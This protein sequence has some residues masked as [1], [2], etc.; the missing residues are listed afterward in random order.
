M[1]GQV[2]IVSPGGS[3]LAELSAAEAR[4]WGEERV[5]LTE[6]GEYDYELQLREGVGGLQCPV[7]R[8]S[9][10]SDANIERGRILP[11]GH[12]GLLV[13]HLVDKHD[14]PIASAGV[15]VRSVKVGY[16]S[17]YRSMLN[18]IAERSTDLLLRLPAPAFLRLRPVGAAEPR[19]IAQ[20][21]AF[22][23][24]VVRS[25]AFRNAI[26]RIVAAPHERTVRELQ[27]KDVRIGFTT[28][29][30]AMRQLASRH[31]RI[32]VPEA[33]ALR[34][35]LP[36]LPLEVL[37][38]RSGAGH[39]TPENRFVKFVLAEL[40]NFFSSMERALAGVRTVEAR[41]LASEIAVLHNDIA[42]LASH[43][44]FRHIGDLQ[45]LPL[46]SS[47]LQGRAGYRELLQAWLRFNLAAAL[48]WDGGED[49]YGAGKRDVAT[50]YEY[51]LFFKLL[52]LFVAKFRLPD[53][54][55]SSLLERSSDSFGIRLKRGSHTAVEGTF[56]AHGRSLRVRFSFNRT[57]TRDGSVSANYP[58]AGSWTRTMRPD[59]T[60][61]IW[62]AEF[63]EQES[64]EQELVAHLHFDAKYRIETLVELFGDGAIERADPDVASGQESEETVKRADLLKMHAYRDAIRRTAGAY[65]LY[66]GHENIMWRGYH[67][68]LPGVGAF[69]VSPGD[70]SGFDALSIFI[71]DV[72][73][74]LTD[75]ASQR[76]AYSYGVY[77]IHE[78]AP[79]QEEWRLKAP[80]R[81][82]DGK[83]VTPASEQLVLAAFCE[84]VEL[85]RRCLERLVYGFKVE[86][87]MMLAPDYG[88]V[89][90]AL[91]YSP[92]YA[93]E[94]RLMRVVPGFSV[95]SGEVYAAM[96]GSEEGADELYVIYRLVAEN[97]LLL[98]RWSAASLSNA[99]LWPAPAIPR[100][101]RLS[102]LQTLAL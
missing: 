40:D 12:T 49:V 81:G 7:V 82:S 79:L 96:L 59:Y 80:E 64:E 34:R 33:H 21:F 36:S 17:D 90:F 31:P 102:H 75:R 68:I 16:R 86:G 23:R 62:P 89:S 52:D 78:V 44:F 50:L 43:E 87:G 9:R 45:E 92:E 61:T 27:L 29:V 15:E 53:A 74:N 41:R 42:E 10:L 69:A 77:R 35:Q 8:R 18:F 22:A 88:S 101:I 98:W 60:L 26:A 56:S 54:T 66:P 67:E 24:Y 5:Q 97:E 48:D 76:E 57:F 20:R 11:R 99:G 30:G 72:V 91:L 70:S 84:S 39:D 100:I 85:S 2:R 73:L 51:W 55:I 71:D 47:V 14:R 94:A 65:V 25:D 63:S 83:R 93:T 3:A 58:A 95:V 13:L 32:P 37:R 28:S 19:T 38:P 4:E 1:R 6:N 46:G